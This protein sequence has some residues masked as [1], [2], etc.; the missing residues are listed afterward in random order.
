MNT[1]RILRPFFN[2]VDIQIEKTE[3]KPFE[4]L[5]AKVK[6]LFANNLNFP[7]QLE[8]LKN[9]KQTCHKDNEWVHITND[10]DLK[11]KTTPFD[12]RKVR[13]NGST[14]DLIESAMSQ[15][16]DRKKERH[17]RVVAHQKM[18]KNSKRAISESIA[19][20]DLQKPIF[21]YPLDETSLIDLS[22]TACAPV[23]LD[24]CADIAE[25]IG[26]RP[27]MEDAHFALEIEQGVLAGVFDGHCG[28]RT[29]QAIASYFPRIFEEQM[30]LSENHIHYAFEKTF[31][32]LHKAFF[33]IFDDGSTGVVS[34]IDVPKNLIYTATLGDSEASISRCIDDEYSLIPLSCV[35]DWTSKKDYERC[36]ASF[37][38]DKS[39][40]DAFVKA[41][42]TLKEKYLRYSPLEVTNYMRFPYDGHPGPNLSRAF[43]DKPFFTY[44]G[45][46]VMS[47]RPKISVQS[48][49]PG[50]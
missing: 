32:I 22:T 2:P 50:D 44:N 24:I 19:D 21:P 31:E 20:Y 46:E 35:R 29:A 45:V 47:R 37:K 5:Q 14:D 6:E 8:F 42:S 18:C 10:E 11:L 36:A 4:V 25:D 33:D 3:P 40:A 34:F 48:I 1:F 38:H 12:F 30:K 26:S 23:K 28:S 15:I 41:M 13:I 16:T 9:P 49:K 7:F 43:G 27:T 17:D 39:R